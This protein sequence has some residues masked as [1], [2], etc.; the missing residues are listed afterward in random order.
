MKTRKASP[1]TRPP[2]VREGRGRGPADALQEHVQ[3]LPGGEGHGA[4][5]GHAVRGR[6]IRDTLCYMKRLRRFEAL[7]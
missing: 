7:K 5:E 3:L 6:L 2:E 4:L 1:E